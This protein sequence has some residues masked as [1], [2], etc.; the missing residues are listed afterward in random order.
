MRDTPSCDILVVGAGPAG[1]TAAAAAARGGA[2][3]VLIDSKVRIGEQPHCGEFVPERLF[4]EAPVE[5]AAIIQKVD[6]M[7]TRVIARARTPGLDA[8]PSG[9]ITDQDTP[10]DVERS[11][12]RRSQVPSPGSLIDRVRFDRDLAR[13]AAAQGVTVFCSTRLLRAENGG[14]AVQHGGETGIFRPRLT[15]ACDGACST[16]ATALAIKPLDVLRGLQMEVPLAKPMNKT[17][18]F[19]DQN[20]VGGYGWVFPKGKVANVGL[21]AVLGNRSRMGKMLEQFA[22]TL[23]REG[24]IR[25]GVLAR[26]GGLIPVS[27]MRDQLVVGSVVFCG[28]AA[29][30]T[31]PITGAGIPQAMFS[32]ELAGRAAAD[33]IKKGDTSYLSEYESE[34]R[35]RYQ[36]I[37]NHALTKRRLMMRRWD[38][39][40][41]GALCEETWIGFKGYRKRI[42]STEE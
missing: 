39:L 29:G 18:I 31:H 11:E 27:G 25:R 19:L 4:S 23:C 35:N 22:E 24:L 15:I 38:D 3:T 36:G 33:A 5:T 16:V 30:L 17:L 10:G 40:D 32:G 2:K 42:R 28:D 1:C 26:S 34:I 21:G 6:R 20:F 41:F 12:C 9:Q 37:I 13:E 8:I 14:W 7:E